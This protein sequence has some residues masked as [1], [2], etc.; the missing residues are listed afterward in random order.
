MLAPLYLTP[1]PT[2]SP[3]CRGDIYEFVPIPWLNPPVYILRN[4]QLGTAEVL[5]ASRVKDAFRVG[6]RDNKEFI[7]TEGKTRFVVVFSHD[8]EL[9]KGQTYVLVVPVYTIN[10]Q[11]D[12]PVLLDNLRH[13]RI[14]NAFYLPPEAALSISESYADFRRLQ[15]L[16][17]DFLEPGKRRARL[18]PSTMQAMLAQFSKFMLRI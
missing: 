5:Q 2:S 14:Y 17:R 4:W 12:D 8:A 1:S 11:S 13:H 9:R 7:I 10:A 6:A 16:H 15:P 18:S 3:V